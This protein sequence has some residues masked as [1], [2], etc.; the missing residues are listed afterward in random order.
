VG[1]KGSTLFNF[2]NGFADGGIIQDLLRSIWQQ[3]RRCY[4][5]VNLARRPA[6]ILEDAFEGI[7]AEGGAGG[8]PG[9]RR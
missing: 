8:E 1:R 3:L 4:T 2:S 7:V 6:G 5:A 9:N